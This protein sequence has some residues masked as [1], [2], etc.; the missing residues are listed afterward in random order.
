MSFRPQGHVDIRPLSRF[1][2]KTSREAF[3]TGRIT[4]RNRTVFVLTTA[5]PTHFGISKEQSNESME[6]FK[7]QKR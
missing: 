7:I 6:L 4:E 1:S 3:N 5:K 2:H